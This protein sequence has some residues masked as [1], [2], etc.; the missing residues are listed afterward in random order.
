MATLSADFSLALRSF[1]LRLALEVERTV[2]LVGPS[3]AGKSSI[4]RVIAGLLRPA[5]GRLALDGDVWLDLAIGVDRRP[6]ERRVGLVFQEYALFPHLTVRANVAYGGKERVEEML[7]RFRISHLARARP[8][9]L[10]GG[11]RQRVA[12]ARA[13]ARNPGVLLLDEPL[14]ALDAH[15]KADVRV[16]LQ[17]VLHS[18]ALPTLIVTHDYEDAAALAGTVG[19]IVDGDLRQLGSPRELVAQPRDPFVASLTGANL[20]RGRA[21]RTENGLTSVRLD[22][23]ELVYSTDPGDGD[24]GVV[25]YPWD[26]SIGRTHAE[27]SAM[28]LLRGEIAS[29][30]QLGNRVRVR[31]GPLTA[32]VTAASAERLELARGG[33][34]FVSFKATGTRLVPMS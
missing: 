25:V 13:L 5:T 20:L 10:S 6:D 7:E 19:V 27:D 11:E 3:G 32:E 14:A 4:L 23:G 1:E 8:G 29:I 12:L 16:E 31:V 18:F 30:A 15:T 9:E 28:N 24:V 2:A 22:S 33:L 21:S 34:A 17:E 26:V